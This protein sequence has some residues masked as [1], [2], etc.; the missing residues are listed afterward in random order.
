MP[1]GRVDYGESVATGAKREALEEAGVEVDLT[2][3]VRLDFS[4]HSNH[5]RFRAIYKAELTQSNAKLR[6][7]S[8]ADDEII[9]ACWVEPEELA[10]GR[11]VRSHEMI[12]L[13]QHFNRIDCSRLPPASIVQS[14]DGYPINHDQ[15]VSNTTMSVTLIA[16]D[17]T[18]SFVGVRSTSG[19]QS[20]ITSFM[21]HPHTFQRFSE[22]KWPK[23]SLVGVVGVRYMAPHSDIPTR[24]T[25]HLNVIF[26]AKFKKA[27]LK[28]WMPLTDVN[29][30]AP[31]EAE[32]VTKSQSP[33]NVYPLSLI[34][35]EGSPLPKF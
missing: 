21:K 13:F 31:E 11:K 25:G 12:H 32:L 5:C 33:N 34:D 10:D 30:L 4:P 22:K 23:G 24:K 28:E 20:L 2:H 16:M 3:L 18:N 7:R 6:D 19:R 35:L 15:V 27:D 14:C 26:L 8:T 29:Q 1:A 17:E 9:E